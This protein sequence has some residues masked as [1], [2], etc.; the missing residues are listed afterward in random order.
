[1]ARMGNNCSHDILDFHQ[2]AVTDCF[3]V[4]ASDK[5]WEKTN[6]SSSEPVQLDCRSPI[7]PIERSSELEDTLQDM[8]EFHKF[9]VTS[10]HLI[11]IYGVKRE[12]L[13]GTS[14]KNVNTLPVTGLDLPFHLS[15]LRTGPLP[16]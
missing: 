15:T 2:T 10:S 16:D 13:S 14:E 8:F 1:M 5:R 6:T 11:L 7:D 9:F 3:P 4:K 12:M